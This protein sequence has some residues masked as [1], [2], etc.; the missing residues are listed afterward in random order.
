MTLPFI[1]SPSFRSSPSV[2]RRALATLICALLLAACTRNAP[3]EGGGDLLPEQIAAT[4]T[5]A[6]TLPP[7][8]TPPPSATPQPSAT[9]PPT[10]TPVP[11]ETPTNGPSPTPTGVA[12]DVEDPRYGLNLSAPDVTD[13]FS[14]RYGWFEYSD[15]RAA[16]IIWERGKMVAT[17]NA[18]DGFLW[19]STSGITAGDFYAEITGEV[20]E[21]Q[22]KDAYGLAVRIGGAGYD[23]GYTLEF[24]CD[25]HYRMRKFISGASPEVMLDWTASSHIISGTGATNRFGFLVDGDRLVGF[26]NGQALEEVHDEAF[27]FG[28]FGLFAEAHASSTVTASFQEF[29][30]WNLQP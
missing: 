27:V 21:C 11:T 3:P 24:S 26:A 17:D 15:P 2:P 20:D 9:P 28:N 12:L 13:D 23:R 5:A 8:R 10:D 30:L 29:S 7:S 18:A 16:N 14:T 19:W 4:L 6:P 1:T 25:G 22:A